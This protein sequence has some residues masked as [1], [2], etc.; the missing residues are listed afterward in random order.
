[1][2]GWDG[3]RAYRPT[4]RRQPPRRGDARFMDIVLD[5]R[6]RNLPAL[7]RLAPDRCITTSYVVAP[8]VAD[9]IL[10]A[11]RHLFGC[12]SAHIYQVD[13]C[14]ADLPRASPFLSSFTSAPVQLFPAPPRQRPR[15]NPRR[16]PG[17]Y[18]TPE[19]RPKTPPGSHTSPEDPRRHKTP[20]KPP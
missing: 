7:P 17:W 2:Q 20:P 14:A 3:N 11:L 1:M 9:Y 18:S 15:K 4:H 19:K 16:L 5:A 12:H 8:L 6:R 13:I 10:S